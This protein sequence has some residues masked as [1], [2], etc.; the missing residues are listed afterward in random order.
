M[1]PRTHGAHKD[2][3][4]HK[5]GRARRRGR[6]QATPLREFVRLKGPAKSIFPA[7]PL[8]ARP[9]SR[10]AQY[11]AREI[12]QSILVHSAINLVHSAILVVETRLAASPL[13]PPALRRE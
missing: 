3:S 6:A 10:S 1:R 13:A 5:K 4:T 2:G 12:R 8:T 11:Y 7:S 9:R